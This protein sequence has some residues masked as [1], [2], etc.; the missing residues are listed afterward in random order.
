ML[1]CQSG[2]AAH[3][4]AATCAVTVRRGCGHADPD[5]LLT[6]REHA[7]ALRRQRPDCPRCGADGAVLQVRVEE[8]FEE[9]I[10]IAVRREVVDASLLPRRT[11]AYDRA[12]RWAD[13]GGLPPVAGYRV[14]VQWR[15]HP[16]GY[17]PDADMLQ[18][19]VT[20]AVRRTPG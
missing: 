1:Y 11:L 18:A 16:D 3:R 12:C 7:E 14:P 13:A 8:V 6:C 5:P 17:P 20:L 15:P 19:A 10:V 4:A 9:R 2:P